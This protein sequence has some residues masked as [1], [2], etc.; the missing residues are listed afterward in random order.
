MSRA[1]CPFFYLLLFC[2][3]W[4]RHRNVCERCWLNARKEIDRYI[5][6][7]NIY[8]TVRLHFRVPGIRTEAS[9]WIWKCVWNENSILFACLNSL[10]FQLLAFAIESSTHG[11]RHTKSNLIY[12]AALSKH[13][14]HSTSIP[15]LSPAHLILFLITQ[16][17][18]R[19]ALQADEARIRISL[20]LSLSRNYN[21]AWNLFNSWKICARYVI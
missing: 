16:F 20:F 1:R 4:M 5:I 10:Y 12:V 2:L 17:T 13:A 7:T 8:V 21:I 15:F 18:H 14:L 9:I 19:I 6:N 11:L 3:H